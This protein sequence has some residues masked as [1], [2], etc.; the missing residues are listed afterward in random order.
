[1]QTESHELLKLRAVEWRVYY[2]Y[3]SSIWYVDGILHLLLVWHGLPCSNF[4]SSRKYVVWRNV[5]IHGTQKKTLKEYSISAAAA[6][7]FDSICFHSHRP[8]FFAPPCLHACSSFSNCSI[9]LPMLMVR[10]WCYIVNGL[11]VLDRICRPS[12]SSHPSS[13]SS[14]QSIQISPGLNILSQ[15]FPLPHSPPLP[16]PLCRSAQR[17]PHRRVDL[18]QTLM[19]RSC[20]QSMKQLMQGQQQREERKKRKRE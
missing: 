14:D 2:S 15:Y 12:Y 9:S 3:R 1:M 7:I 5:L 18:I 19:K 20:D 13:T 4:S 6:L 11:Q 10:S 17:R 16:Y 8:A